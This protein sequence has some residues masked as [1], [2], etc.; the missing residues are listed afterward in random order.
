MRRAHCSSALA[1]VDESPFLRG[2]RSKIS[3]RAPD[4][5]ARRVRRARRRGLRRRARDASR[6]A[7]ARHRTKR[8]KLPDASC[9]NSRD[10][11]QR[12]CRDEQLEHARL[13]RGWH[14][15]G[16][17]HRFRRSRLHLR[18]A[19]EEGNTLFAPRARDGSLLAAPGK[20][21]DVARREI[22]CPRVG[23]GQNFSPRPSV[24]S[25]VRAPSRLQCTG[26]SC[27]VS[28]DT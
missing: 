15:D 11:Q 6:R 1:C 12:L 4:V 18:R 27:K 10:G 25:G 17:S 14:G 8:V 19:D 23:Q 3:S 7:P 24:T 21:R 9:A 22:A 28:P 13:R 2:V 26:Q 5:V 16:A 20:S